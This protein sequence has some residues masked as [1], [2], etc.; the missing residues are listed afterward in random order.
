[1][2]GGVLPGGGTSLVVEWDFEILPGFLLLPVTLP[3]PRP[4]GHS[5]LWLRGKNDTAECTEQ[6][7][8]FLA[9]M[10]QK[11]EAGKSQ[12]DIFFSLL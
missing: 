9:F 1:M 8:P 10:F 3:Q 5:M 2:Y 7:S 11:P 6:K 4:L 12:E